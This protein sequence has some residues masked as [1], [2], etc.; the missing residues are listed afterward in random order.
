WLRVCV[1]LAAG[2]VCGPF[3]LPVRDTSEEGKETHLCQATALRNCLPLPG[4]S[5]LDKLIKTCPVWLQLNM[6]QE[7]AGAILGKETAGIF[8]V[9][10]EGNMNNMVL[11]VRLPVQNEAPSVL[12]YN[13]KEEKS[14]KFFT[15]FWSCM[16][17]VLLHEGRNSKPFATNSGVWIKNTRAGVSCREGKRF[18]LVI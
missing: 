17:S 2:K 8:L 18:S 13:I 14:S 10:R 7:R 1:F 6:N 12:E 16:C 11:A 15:L 9:R 3:P 4:I 5:I